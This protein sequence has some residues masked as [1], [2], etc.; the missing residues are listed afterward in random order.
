MRGW[1]VSPYPTVMLSL[2]CWARTPGI[3][4]PHPARRAVEVRPLGAFAVQADLVLLCAW[5]ESAAHLPTDASC[6]A[7]DA[8]G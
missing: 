6:R 3:L 8:G 1:G 4:A 2:L 7:W 5:V